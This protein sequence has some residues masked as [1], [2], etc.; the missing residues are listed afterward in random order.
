MALFTDGVLM[1]FS[2]DETIIDGLSEP[3][4]VY[5]IKQGYVK[6]YTITKDGDENLMLIHDTG[7]FIPLVWALDGIHS[8]GLY[9]MAMTDVTVLITSKEKLRSAMSSDI[10]L[11]QEILK[12]SVNII[13]AYGQRIQSLELRSAR[14]RI[15]A[16]LLSL[17]KRFG[18]IRGNSTIIDVPVTHQDIANSINMT[19]ETASRALGMLFEEGLLAQEDHQFVIIDTPEMQKELLR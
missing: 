1:K 9:Y 6:A 16:E 3:K 14:E 10:R 11:S 15:I 5:L 13:S 17:A 12:Q 4:G 19:R 7:E 8:A 2:K 18:R